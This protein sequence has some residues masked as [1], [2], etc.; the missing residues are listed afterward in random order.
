M[1]DFEITLYDSN[2]RLI[3]RVHSVGF[4]RGQAYEAARSAM[5]TTMGAAF[6]KVEVI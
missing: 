6:F 5:A 1:F 3:R 4:R 2:N